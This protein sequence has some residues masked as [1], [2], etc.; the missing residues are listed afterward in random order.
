M[1]FCSHCGSNRIAL[2]IPI[3]DSIARYCCPD[4]GTVHYQNPKIIVGCLPIYEG[5]ILL[6][7]RAIAPRLGFWNLPAGFMENGERAEQGAARETLEEANC[8]VNITRLHSIYSIPHTNQVYLIFLA[9]MTSAEYSATSE[10]SE[11]NLFDEKDIPWDM[12]AFSST[13]FTLEKYIENK[14]ATQVHIGSF[15]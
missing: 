14:E 5:K 9:D 13:R 10:S 7:K 2:S 3:G 6:C 4:C 1:N 11:V 15:S 12:L 8:V